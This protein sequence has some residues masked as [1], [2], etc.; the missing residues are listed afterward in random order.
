MNMHIY[1]Q[2][3]MEILNLQQILRV[4]YANVYESPN[5]E[6]LNI[7]IDCIDKKVYTYYDMMLINTLASKVK[8][9]AIPFIQQQMMA[10]LMS[11]LKSEK[12]LYCY[13]YNDRNQIMQINNQCHN[14]FSALN[15]AFHICGITVF[16]MFL[17]RLVY[18][19]IDVDLIDENDIMHKMYKIVI[20]ILHEKLIIDLLPNTRNKKIITYIVIEGK[21]GI[22]LQCELII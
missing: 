18:Y 12:D 13:K 5:I 16:K 6:Q 9:D 22:D 7:L 15:N 14:I 21:I 8:I 4:I 10:I 2:K 17:K 19:L 20:A 11:S 3:Q 1:K